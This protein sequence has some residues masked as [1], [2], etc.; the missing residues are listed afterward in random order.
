MA[1]SEPEPL[2][3]EKS[4]RTSSFPSISLPSDASW[5]HKALA[6]GV[7]ALLGTAALYVHSRQ[8]PISKLALNFD[9]RALS[10]N[11]ALEGEGSENDKLNLHST[12]ARAALQAYPDLRQV[13]KILYRQR[14]R[15]FDPTMKER[16]NSSL[17]TLK[18]TELLVFVFQ[19]LGPVYF[20]S[21]SSSAKRQDAMKQLL[22][23]AKD[24][25][26]QKQNSALARLL[27][28]ELQVL[29]RIK[30]QRITQPEVVLASPSLSFG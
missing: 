22:I 20:S 21:E 27:D 23:V 24:Y 25:W 13:F 16:G 26:N 7:A 6:L 2:F 28:N 29:D 9:P 5:Q 30:I 12:A 3:A 1:E 15:L 8:K 17:L 4:A 19:N 14:D 10:P 18:L 11:Y